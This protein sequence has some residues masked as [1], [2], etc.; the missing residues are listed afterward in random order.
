MGWEKGRDEW[1]ALVKNTSIKVSGE[2]NKKRS[3]NIEHSAK[4]VKKKQN[5]FSGTLQR[6]GDP[7]HFT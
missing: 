3:N 6:M 1:V 7:F 5:I 2:M 4:N